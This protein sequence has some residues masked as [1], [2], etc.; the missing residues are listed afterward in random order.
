MDKVVD[1]AE[2]RAARVGMATQFEKCGSACVIF[3]N[4]ELVFRAQVKD[5]EARTRTAEARAEALKA[6]ADA[7]EVRAAYVNAALPQHDPK[8]SLESVAD[9]PQ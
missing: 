3:T 4:A 9:M 2:N 1:R 7:A 8:S 6:A 5:L